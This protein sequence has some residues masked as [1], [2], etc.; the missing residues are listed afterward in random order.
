MADQPATFVFSDWPDEVSLRLLNANAFPEFVSKLVD[1]ARARLNLMLAH[2]ATQSAAIDASVFRLTTKL[3]VEWSDDLGN[4]KPSQDLTYLARVESTPYVA[5]LHGFL[6]SLKS[7]LDVYVQLTCRMYLATGRCPKGRG[8]VG[9]GE[10]VWALGKL[11]NWLRDRPVGSVNSDSVADAILSHSQNWITDAVEDRDSFTHHG[12]PPTLRHLEVP[13]FVAGRI[14]RPEDVRRPTLRGLALDE[15]C[16]DRVDSLG[17][18][19]DDTL[20][21]LPEIDTSL[22]QPWTSARSHLPWA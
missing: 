6:Y 11:I 14:W 13:L 7:Y 10:D 22:I 20:R 17:A 19:M 8:K 1:A 2:A 9:Q 3:D 15:Y 12:D 5:P 18:L 4:V 16:F 21:L